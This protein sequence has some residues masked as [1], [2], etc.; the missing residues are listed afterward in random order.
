MPAELDDTTAR[1]ARLMEA[2]R[3]RPA[4]SACRACLDHLGDYVAAQLAGQ[5]YAVVLPAVAA[6][7]DACPDCSTAYARLY[8]LEVAEATGRLPEPTRIPA[9]DLSFL[10]AAGPSLIDQL[11]SAVT[12]L[13]DRLRFQ[14]SAELL[15]LLQPAPLPALRGPASEARYG[16]QIVSLEPAEGLQAEIPFR[17]AVYRDA[18]RPELC[19]VEVTAEPPG[20]AWPDLAGITIRLAWPGGERQAVT[21]VWGLASFEDVPLES[22]TLLSFELDII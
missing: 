1:R 13:G 19:L 11:R 9:P 4:D 8:Q 6:H 15:P 18:Q 7:L 5:D 20:R 17:L 12:R 14:L 2:I 16:E 3:F 10:R 21:D 22:L